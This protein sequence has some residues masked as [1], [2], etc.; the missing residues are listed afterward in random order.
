MAVVTNREGEMTGVAGEPMLFDPAAWDVARSLASRMPVGAA[1]G[2][3]PSV[4]IPHSPQTTSAHGLHSE[5]PPG[6]DDGPSR[7]R[8]TSQ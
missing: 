3:D 6:A 5:A 7:T 2:L 4:P 1:V 8:I